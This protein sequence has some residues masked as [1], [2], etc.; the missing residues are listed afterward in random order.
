MFMVVILK[1]IYIERVIFSLPLSF[2]L[3]SIASN[4]YERMILQ[5]FRDVLQIL[6]ALFYRIILPRSWHPSG[7]RMALR[8]VYFQD[9]EWKSSVLSPSLAPGSSKTGFPHMR[10]P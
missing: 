10:V 1:I 7:F 4:V 3:S 6:Q 8:R 5:G 9:P 2:S